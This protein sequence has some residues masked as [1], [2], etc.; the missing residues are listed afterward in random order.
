MEAVCRTEP[1]EHPASQHI[2]R[3]LLEPPVAT[4]MKYHH[5][6][7]P[8]WIVQSFG[9]TVGN[10][11][12]RQVL[13]LDVDVAPGPLNTVEKQGLDLIDGRLPLRQRGGS[14]NRDGDA[15][16][17]RITFI[18]PHIRLGRRRA[19]RKSTARRTF[20]SFPGQFSKRRGHVTTHH[21]LDI[22]KRAAR[23][24]IQ[25]ARGMRGEMTLRIPTTLSE[26]QASDE[27]KSVLDDDN[28]LMVRRSDRMSG[29]FHEMQPA[30]SRQFRRQPPLPFVPE[31]H[32]KVPREHINMEIPSSD[33]QIM[34]KLTEAV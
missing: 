21:Q 6:F 29:I 12:G 18:R 23:T 8:I 3:M 4:R 22:M 17:A 7:R 19:Q 31:D 15:G 2:H 11:A 20:P 33:Q 34:E 27:R 16:K 25:Y 5:H 10:C 9:K 14:G 30:V 26:I 13:R 24:L 28:F 1:L 32:V